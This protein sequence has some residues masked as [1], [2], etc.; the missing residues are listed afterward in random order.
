MKPKDVRVLRVNCDHSEGGKW[1]VHLLEEEW[2]KLC[3]SYERIFQDRFDLLTVETKEGMLASEW[4]MRTARAERECNDLRNEVARL[5]QDAI[6]FRNACDSAEAA[7]KQ[8]LN[9]YERVAEALGLADWAEG[10]G[11]CKVAPFEDVLAAAREYQR[12]RG[13]VEELRWGNEMACENTP[14][15]A[16]ECPGCATARERSDRNET[17]PSAWEYRCEACGVSLADVEV[18]G[19]KLPRVRR[20]D[21]CLPKRTEVA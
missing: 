4:V 1:R 17:G 13:E 10:Q 11:I 14:N 7:L 8:A 9:E 20:C 3:E 16:C 5:K 21:C 2:N 6:A 15:P 12:L 19:K 18:G